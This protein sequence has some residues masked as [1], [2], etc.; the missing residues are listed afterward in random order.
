MTLDL[1]AHQASCPDPLAR[2][3]RLSRASDAAHG[4]IHLAP[5]V[6]QGA[7][8]AVITRDTRGVELNDAQRLTHFPA[9]PLVSLSAFQDMQGGLVERTP[10]GPRWQPFGASVTLSGSQCQPTASWSPTGGRGCMICFTADT[11]RSLFGLD[12]AA[13]QDRCVPAQTV[14]G[15]VWQPLLQ[16]L[17]DAPDDAAT[18]AALQQHL[19]ARWQALQ[20]RASATPS[21]RQIGRHWVARLGLQ[22]HEWRN[23]HSARQVERRIKAHSGRSL[24]EWQLLVKTEGVFFNARDRY[25]AGES[26]DWAALAFDEGFADQAH[27]SR[28]AKRITGFSPG[29]FAQ[30]FAE[31]ESFWLYRLWV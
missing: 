22:A 17:L 28:T 31:D 26:V 1:L 30:R 19:A 25:D 18:L 29:E 6:L 23:T 12:P 14:L 13:V 24:R 27:L 15:E 16:A 9:S 21:L 8:V 20:G 2:A 5:A 4:R 3:A 10:D 7:V 11:A